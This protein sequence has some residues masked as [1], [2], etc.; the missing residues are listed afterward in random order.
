L[1]DS[2]AESARAGPDCCIFLGPLPAARL[3]C[4][5][6]AV[7]LAVALAGQVRNGQ[8]LL[9]AGQLLSG[10][11][12]LRGAL[13]DLLLTGPDP[14]RSLAWIGGGILE[15]RLRSGRCRRVR[16]AASTLVWSRYLLLVLEGEGGPPVRLLLGPGNVPRCQLAAL[17][18]EW[19]RA[20]K[21]LSGP[22]A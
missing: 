6:F 1:P 13:A 19:L 21:G 7:L 12:V 14:P 16:A 3:L 11:V 18:R 15:V 17:R 4:A 8:V 10:L 9:A 22:L 20:R 2:C 5:A